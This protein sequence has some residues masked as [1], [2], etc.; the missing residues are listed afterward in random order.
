MQR[1]PDPP[2]P[3]PPQRKYRSAARRAAGA[4]RN[5]PSA[6]Q[7]PSEAPHT[8][9]DSTQTQ[10]PPPPTAPPAQP[11][12]VRSGS[13][14][15][16]RRVDILLPR[17]PA[18]PPAAS[19]PPANKPRPPVPNRPQ[20]EETSN[21][22]P[23]SR[24]QKEEREFQLPKGFWSSLLIGALCVTAVIVAAVLFGG[25]MNDF[26]AGQD[27]N[28][29]AEA[30]L[31]DRANHPLYYREL[32]EKYAERF[33]LEPALIAAVIL[34]ESSFNRE[35]ISSDEARGLMQIIP[36]TAQ[37]IADTTGEPDFTHERLYEPELNIR[38]GAWYLNYL[39]N[40][41][42]ND[43]RK[44]VCGYHAGQGNVAVWLRNPE[45]SPDGVTLAVIPEGVG[46]TGAY[47]ARVQRAIVAY[48][49]YHFENGG[50]E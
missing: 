44:M 5:D 8:K 1:P 22:Q 10:A 25:W 39:A 33:D 29:R 27:E 7:T 48:R 38:M 24:I 19:P 15:P 46:G 28:R 37:W 23:R 4:G 26:R 36:D 50:Y 45:Y 21:H 34:C 3:S 6:E 40:L 20:R 17:P 41:F 30:E 49:K 18:P 32:I 31:T 47:E 43:V 35:A 2:D 9:R 13:S 42:D 14:S 11:K 16:V 12:L